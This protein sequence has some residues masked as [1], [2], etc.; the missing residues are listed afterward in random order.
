MEQNSFMAAMQQS[1]ARGEG[2]QRVINTNAK[3]VCPDCGQEFMDDSHDCQTC[4][5]PKECLKSIDHFHEGVETSANNYR[6]ENIVNIWAKINLYVGVIAGIICI[7]AGI[8]FL[9]DWQEQILGV[10]LIVGG[11]M[12]ILFSILFWAF[13]KLFSNMSYRLTSID[14]KLK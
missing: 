4:G 5:C 6:A 2:T 13:L 8:T 7:I 9:D 3:F 1:T 10:C 14:N 11:L 12:F